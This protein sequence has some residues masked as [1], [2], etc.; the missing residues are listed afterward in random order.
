MED[1]YSLFAA[2]ERPGEKVMA[3]IVDVE[4]TAYKKEG[5]SMVFIEDGTQIGMLSAGCLE[6]DLAIRAAYVLKKGEVTT[7]QYDL[8]EETDLTWGQ[9]AGCNGIITILLETIDER[10]KKDLDQLKKCLDLNIPVLGL[11]KIGELGEYLFLPQEEE[12]FGWWEGEIPYRFYETESG[13]MQ[14]QPI[15]QHLYRPKPRLIVFGAGPDMQPMVS[16]AAKWLF[17]R[18]SSAIGASIFAGRNFF[19]KQ[20]FC[21][22]DFRLIFSAKLISGRQIMLS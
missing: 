6:E 22:L 11:K 4:G 8:R 9:G 16:L 18:P 2:I 10:L 13:M 7:V 12:P 1:I 5:S 14:D 21:W 19:L 15:F 3:T 17:C 20:I